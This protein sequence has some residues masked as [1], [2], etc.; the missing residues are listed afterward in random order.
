MFRISTDLTFLRATII[1]A[2]LG[3]LLVTLHEGSASAAIDSACV[4]LQK[5]KSTIYGFHPSQISQKEREAKSAQMDRFWESVKSM[6]QPGIDC[7][8]QLIVAEQQDGFFVFDAASLLL[9]LDKSATSLEVASSGI[10]KA[11]L[12][13]LD[14]SSY[15]RAGRF[16]RCLQQLP[17]V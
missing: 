1:V 11:D 4:E 13:D 10:A 14:S 17:P 3:W 12:N 8:K 2:F 9:S 5:D 15:I 16:K 7:L 6:R